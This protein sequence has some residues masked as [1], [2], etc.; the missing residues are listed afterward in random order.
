MR[1]FGAVNSYRGES[2]LGESLLGFFGG[3][4]NR[5]DDDIVVVVGG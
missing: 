5:V 3:V 4:I 1:R 2:L